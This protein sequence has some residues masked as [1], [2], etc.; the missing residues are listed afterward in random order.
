MNYIDTEVTQNLVLG[1]ADDSDDLELGIVEFTNI[2]LY[3]YM[4][5]VDYT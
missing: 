4:L 5:G 3:L 2:G 1:L